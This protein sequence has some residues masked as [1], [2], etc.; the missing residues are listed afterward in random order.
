M[1]KIAHAF[2]V[3]VALILSACG[4]PRID[5]SSE[6]A[7]KASI[8]KVRDALDEKKKDEFD[9]ALKQVAFSKLDLKAIF[10]GSAT[11]DSIGKDVLTSLNGKTAS[12]VIADAKKMQEEREAKEREQALSEIKELEQKKAASTSAAEQLKKFEVSRSRFSQKSNGY[13]GKQP[14]IELTVKNGTSSVV[15][16]AYFEGT[17]ASPGRAVPWHKDEFNYKISGG[18]EPGESAKWSL[19]PNM[20][21]GWGKVEAPADAVFTVVVTQL[22]G[23]DGKPVYSSREYSEQDAERLAQLTSK[24]AA[25]A[26]N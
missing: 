4:D 8:Q 9:S 26:S 23:P 18:L 17:L 13:F 12:D 6:E 5:G 21:M 2:V 11:P 7:Y 16:H 15:S 24:Y 1:K 3:S 19:A 25:P 10:S 20:F 22:D 14:I